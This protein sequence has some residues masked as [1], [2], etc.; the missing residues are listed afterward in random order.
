MDYE[1][2]KT[3]DFLSNAEFRDWVYAPTSAS[4]SFW[5]NWMDAHPDKTN[6]LL[7]AREILLSLQ[8]NEPD[9]I[10]G[11]ERIE[12]LKNILSD[13]KETLIKRN[14]TYRLKPYLRVVAS[15]V[16]VVSFVFIYIQYIASGK[17]E[18]GKA[19]PGWVVKENPRGQK[20]RITL[21]D[22]S[23]V[24]LNSESRIEYRVDF[25]S[26]RDVKLSGEAF[27]EVIKDAERPFRVTS[28]GVITTAIGTSFNISAFENE[29]I[30]VGLVT[31]KVK[32]EAPVINENMMLTPGQ[33]ASFN[34]EG[35]QLTLASF[36]EKKLLAWTRQ[37]IVFESANFDEMKTTLERWYGVEIRVEGAVGN[38]RFS[39][40]FD[41]ESLQRVLERIAFVEQFSFER[42]GRQV[43]VFFD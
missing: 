7:K 20:A 34:E 14:D 9:E 19:L 21:P 22:G 15:V 12:I 16:L 40:E 42:N 10:P 29:G 38:I 1:K 39:G 41:H 30:E 32:V 33:Q 28:K 4:E 26:S 11:D 18:K 24:W 36:D 17:D 6:N 8:Y 2:F 37:T 31:G 43:N 5:K 23:K 35:R 27:F 3:E 13:G 25:T